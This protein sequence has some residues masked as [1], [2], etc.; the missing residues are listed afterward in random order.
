MNWESI[1][2]AWVPALIFV[3]RS[4][5]LTFGTLRILTVARGRKSLAWILAICQATLFVTAIAG[6]QSLLTSSE[7]QLEALYSRWEELEQ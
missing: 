2:A 5:D 1:P 7:A 4:T 3:A 6:V